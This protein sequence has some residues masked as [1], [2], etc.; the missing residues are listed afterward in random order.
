[1]TRILKFEREGCMPCKKLDMILNKLGIEV[2]HRNLDTYESDSDIS[3]YQL[4]STPTLVRI[5]ND[6]SFDKLAGIQHTTSEFKEFC[7]V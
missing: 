7:E 2:E 4:S 3:L 6:G 1:M 5:N